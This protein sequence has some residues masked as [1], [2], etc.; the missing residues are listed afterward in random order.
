MPRQGSTYISPHG[1]VAD[2][3]GE[4]WHDWDDLWAVSNLGRFKA[5]AR[6]V[7][8]PRGIWHQRERLLTLH[9]SGAPDRKV[10]S[11]RYQVDGVVKSIS[12]YRAM[13]LCFIGD[14]EDDAH[15]LCDG[16]LRVENLMLKKGTPRRVKA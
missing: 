7:E 8:N 16:D 2:L 10:L 14:L 12:I 3:P 11:A 15:V 13:W 5:Y 4:E 6:A 1:P 9:L